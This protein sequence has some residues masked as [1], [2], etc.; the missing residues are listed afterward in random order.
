MKPTEMNLFPTQPRLDPTKAHTLAGYGVRIRLDPKQCIVSDPGAGEP[1]IVEARFYDEEEARQ[2][3]LSATFICC[4]NEGYAIDGVDLPEKQKAWLQS[5]EGDIN[6]WL[7]AAWA[8]A[9]KGGA[10]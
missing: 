4:V 2:V 6:D 5:M 3:S 9:K 10:R 7:D 8:I 1:A